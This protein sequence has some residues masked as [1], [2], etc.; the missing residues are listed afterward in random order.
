MAGMRERFARA[1]DLSPNADASVD[2]GRQ[3][4]AA[5]VDLLHYVEGLDKAVA[6]RGAEHEFPGTAATHAH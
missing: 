1:R 3:Y 2:A 6:R 4:V 5:Y